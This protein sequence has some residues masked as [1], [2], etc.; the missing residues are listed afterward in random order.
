[1]RSVCEGILRCQPITFVVSPGGPFLAGVSAPSGPYIRGTQK[2]FLKM[3]RK[4]LS[5]GILAAAFCLTLGT[6]DAQA[7]RN[8]CHHRSDRCSHHRSNRCYQNNNWDCQ[9]ASNCEMQQV[10]NN[11]QQT[12]RYAAPA[13]TC[14][15]AQSNACNVQNASF[16]TT[17]ANAS[18]QQ[19]PIEEAPAPAPVATPAPTPIR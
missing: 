3:S 13:A 6:T 4:V 1:M 8:R 10:S 15:N 2:E 16:S 17:P 18:A 14:C 11:C 9:Q 7:S 5:M 19:P 12:V